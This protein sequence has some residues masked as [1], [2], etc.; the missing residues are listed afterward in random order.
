MA[1]NE[2]RYCEHC[3]RNTLFFWESDLIWY[4]DECGNPFGSHPLIRD[5]ELEEALDEF[6]EEFG[7]AVYCETCGNFVCVDEILEESI[8]PYCA[9]TLDMELERKGYVY[10]DETETYKLEDD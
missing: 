3:K 5:K 10:D 4:C 6:E 2:E 1:N 7:P 8:C 9:D